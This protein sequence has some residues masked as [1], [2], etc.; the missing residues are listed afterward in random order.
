VQRFEV[1]LEGVLEK[2]AIALYKPIHW[3]SVVQPKTTMGNFE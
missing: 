2:Q 1:S 3:W